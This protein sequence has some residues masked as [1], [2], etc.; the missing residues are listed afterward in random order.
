MQRSTVLILLL[1]CLVVAAVATW[2][3]S[4]HGDGVLPPN[5]GDSSAGAGNGAANE[6]GSTGSVPSE[7]GLQSTSNGGPVPSDAPH[8]TITVTAKERFVPPP[9]PPLLATTFAGEALPVRV[10][11]G[12]GA[13]F[14]APKRARGNAIIAVDVPSGQLL[15]QVVQSQRSANVARIGSRIV[16]RGKVTDLE[17]QPI[18]SAVVW[19]GE[20]AADG[21]VRDFTAD[22]A[23]EFEADVPAGQGVPMVVRAKGFA[24]QWRTVQ[25]TAETGPLS[26]VLQP[27][28][29]VQIQLATR[30]LAMD[31][32]RAFVVSRGEVS[33]GVSQWPF[34]W[35]CVSGGYEVSPQGQVV[36]DDLPQLGAVGVVIRHPLASL[37]APVKVKLG[38][39]PVRA[40]VPLRM[41][42]QM[43]GVVVDDEGL[44]ISEASV[45]T[46]L[47]GL[48]L[49]GPRS[50]RLFPPHL[51][52]LGSCFSYTNAGGSYVIGLGE[53]HE[54]TLAVRARGYAGR[55]MPALQAQES[56]VVLPWW[57]G[58]DAAL[59]ILP[60][61]DG[62]VWRVSINLGDGIEEV[63]AAD[64]PFEIALP[65]AG[66]FAV[67]ML[68][69]IDGEQ[70]GS[71]DV[72]E[73]M[74]TGPVDLE[75]PSPK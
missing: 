64:E 14:D 60:P 32:A 53:G 18:A 63:C 11:A 58:G 16:V 12:V 8:V 1:G 3:F 45:W 9:S 72:R 67:A 50:Q 15:R 55:D 59:R 25:I 2:A 43:L 38:S 75:T 57:R 51:D 68:L 37:A 48:R 62:E 44:P 33:S 73:L 20:L 22:E 35:Q 47:A 34:F 5:G 28:G 39:K 29:T 21:S 69:H 70:R 19:F 46:L 30:A 26:Q 13:G 40:T 49:D 10:L 65:Y 31:K 52:V 6:N 71:R 54:P 27:A 74:A 41:G 42:P 36:M 7:T 66:S 56:E 24:S 17:Q 4:G 61:V 23:G